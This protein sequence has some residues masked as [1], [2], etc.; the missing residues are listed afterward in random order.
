MITKEIITLQKKRK[1]KRKRKKRSK[2]V[3]VI[4]DITVIIILGD[5]TVV[6]VAVVLVTAAVEVVVVVRACLEQIILGITFQTDIQ[7]KD[8][9]R[10][11][12]I[13]WMKSKKYA[14]WSLQVVLLIV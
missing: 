1:K 4:I 13:L 14:R 2:S 7:R 11:G 3:T 5:I 9:V 8:L 12:I 6:A 10:I